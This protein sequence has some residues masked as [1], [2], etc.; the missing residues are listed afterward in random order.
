MSIK[1]SLEKGNIGVFYVSAKLAKNELEQAQNACEDVIRKIGTIKIL[2]ILDKF[3]G[4]EDA[5]GWEDASFAERND[6]YIDKIAI[7]GDEKW[8]DMAYLFTLKGLRP[9]AIE[10]FES[11]EEASAREWLNDEPK[12]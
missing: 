11:N 4:W 6:K 7:V 9:V 3:T 8:R 10:Y 1:W 2:V 12:G 5:E